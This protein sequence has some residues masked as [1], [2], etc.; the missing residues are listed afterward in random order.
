MFT[1]ADGIH[2]PG[3]STPGLVQ[4]TVANLKTIKLET[5]NSGRISLLTI[6]YWKLTSL[7]IIRVMKGP[8]W[9]IRIYLQ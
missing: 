1:G 2:T 4:E 6:K 5:N 7:L 8:N 9:I 3:F